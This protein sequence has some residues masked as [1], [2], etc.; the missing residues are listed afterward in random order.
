MVRR[1]LLVLDTLCVVNG[2]TLDAA[3]QDCAAERSVIFFVRHPVRGIG[4]MF[5]ATA[6]HHPGQRVVH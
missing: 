5:S 6:D 3:D 4:G 1:C 2:P